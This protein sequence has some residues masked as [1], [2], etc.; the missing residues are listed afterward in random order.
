MVTAFRS[1]LPLSRP[2]GDIKTLIGKTGATLNDLTKYSYLAENGSAA[3]AVA[4]DT[5]NCTDS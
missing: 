5:L 2:S 4:H 1:V 3:V